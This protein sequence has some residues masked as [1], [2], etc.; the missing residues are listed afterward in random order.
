MFTSSIKNRHESV[1]WFT[2]FIELVL[3]SDLITYRQKV[4]NKK[5]SSHSS[6]YYVLITV[7]QSKDIRKLEEVS[8]GHQAQKPACFPT[9]TS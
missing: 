2:N 7:T 8:K 6:R 4:S 9:C 5:A 3:S 1:Y